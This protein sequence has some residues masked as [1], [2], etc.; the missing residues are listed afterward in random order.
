MPDPDTSSALAATLGLPALVADCLVAR[1]LGEPGLAARFLAPSL[2]DLEDPESLDGMDVAVDRIRS[3][4]IRGE[5]IRIVTDYDVDGATSSLILGAA[6]GALGGRARVDRRIPDRFSSGYGFGEAA[7]REA[8]ADGVHLL[9]AA[10]VGI[11]DRASVEIAR[12]GGVDVIICDHHLPEE[13]SQPPAALAVLCPLL[14][15]SGYANRALAA[16]GIALQLARALLGDHPRHDDLVRSFLKLAAIGTVADV[17]D[18][19]VRENRAIVALGL[20]A[21]S[22]GGHAP[23]LQA[24]LAVSGCSNRPMTAGDLGFRIGPRINAAGR[25]E[26]AEVAIRLLTERD[27]VRAHELAAILDGLNRRRQDI[28]E[29]LVRKLLEDEP[30]ISET[31]RF[32]VFAG[33]ESDGWHRGVVGIVAG[34]VRE[35]LRRPVAVAGIQAGVAVASVRSVPAVHAVRALDAAAPLLLRYGGHAAAAGFSARVEDL[36]A[37]EA[38][39][40]Q[41]V[42]DHVAPGDLVPELRVDAT[43]A[44]SRLD[45]ATART[46]ARLEPHGSGHPHPRF[47]VPGVRLERWRLSKG[48]H[49]FF[50]LGGAEAAWWDGA[51][52]LPAVENA[53]IDLVGTLGLDTWQGQV[54][55]RFSVEDARI[56]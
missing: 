14:P 21:L 52:H 56:A 23:G 4:E 28:Q 12:A 53:P 3:A 34:R 19:S 33:Q 45:L 42:A 35:A 5:R 18:L 50:R 29:R 22:A 30:P 26:H 16:C 40:S 43:V 51:R 10:D 38:T 31:R 27:P 13:G 47:L 1:G 8:V 6:L 20:E 46:L 11:R 9:I 24:L 7:A 54:R 41:W 36:P 39:L 32:P 2:K 48:R 17:V 49:L 15:G 37:L 55:C 44:A 25:I